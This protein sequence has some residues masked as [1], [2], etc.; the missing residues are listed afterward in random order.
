MRI[1][2]T[3]RSLGLW[4]R[5]TIRRLL[6]WR[7]QPK[8]K[9]C[10]YYEMRYKGKN[11]MLFV[12]HG[13]NMKGIAYSTGCE[14]DVDG[15]LVEVASF[16]AARWRN[17]RRDRCGW[18]LTVQALLSDEAE[19]VHDFLDLIQGGAVYLTFSTV[20]DAP[21]GRPAGGGESNKQIDKGG[22]AYLTRITYTGQVHSMASFSAEFTGNGELVNLSDAQFLAGINNTETMINNKKTFITNNA[23]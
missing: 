2:R 1:L 7:E 8:T 3:L 20:D 6:R 19:N 12:R 14:L 9:I 18:S 10:R 16:D 5:T 15:G 17:Y 21:N 4:I 23:I 22:Y 11:L 13:E